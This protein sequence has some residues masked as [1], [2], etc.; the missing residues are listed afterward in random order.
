MALKHGQ[1]PFAI[2]RI[3]GLDHQVEDQ[4]APAG[5]Q[6]EL[7]TVLN[8]A[9][10]FDDDVG[11]RLEQ[12]DDLFIGRDRLAMK[13]ATLS[14]CDD[15]LDQRTIA[16]EL[17]LPQCARPSRRSDRPPPRGRNSRQ[18]SVLSIDPRQSAIARAKTRP[19]RL[20]CEKCGLGA[21]R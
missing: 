1:E 18:N 9:P 11:V 13:N 2:R 20:K 3:A 21:T 14:L 6:V 12:A 17:G 8:L 19:H 5:G 16:V 15:P 10:A 7:V 4:A